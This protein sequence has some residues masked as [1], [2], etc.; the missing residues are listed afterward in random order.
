[1]KKLWASKLNTTL[2]L[3]TYNL[4]TEIQEKINRSL[5]VLLY[6]LDKDL[7]IWAI[8]KKL[9]EDGNKNDTLEDT[10][11]KIVEELWAEMWMTDKEMKELWKYLDNIIRVSLMESPAQK[12]S[13]LTAKWMKLKR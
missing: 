8:S 10:V 7:L 5:F 11:G 3:D 12:Q 9:R 13:E 6:S 4:K 1:M 2:D